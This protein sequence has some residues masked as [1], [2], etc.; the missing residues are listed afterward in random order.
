MSKAYRPINQNYVSSRGVWHEGDIL[1]NYLDTLSSNIDNGTE[2]LKTEWLPTNI[3]ATTTLLDSVS[4]YK[5]VVVYYKQTSYYSTARG[6]IIL[7][8]PNNSNF[9]I[10]DTFTLFSYNGS[11]YNGVYALHRAFNL[12][13]STIKYLNSGNRKIV[14]LEGAGVWNV[15]DTIT[16]TRIVGFKKWG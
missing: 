4:N 16:I 10:N 11:T 7:N 15:G 14:G 3:G 9:I 8:S 2:L 6:S 13:G 1:K 12:N 5:T